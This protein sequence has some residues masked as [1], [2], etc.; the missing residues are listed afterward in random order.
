MALVKTKLSG[1]DEPLYALDEFSNGV[2][3][4]T[5]PE[6]DWFVTRAVWRGKL[7]NAVKSKIPFEAGRTHY[8]LC[9]WGQATES[10]LLDESQEA[11]DW[12]EPV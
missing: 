7:L 1:P 5:R 6:G 10:N 4:I 12:S 3:I 8:A 2:R 11:A 9:C